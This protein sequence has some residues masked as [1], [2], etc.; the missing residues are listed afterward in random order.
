[1]LPKRLVC[2]GTMQSIE[3]SAANPI[4]MACAFMAL[5][6]QW[7]DQILNKLLHKYI[8]DYKIG[9]SAVSGQSA[10]QPAVPSQ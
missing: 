4:D 3:N 7:D 5:L 1:M 2:A 9:I 8:Y 10:S 6:G